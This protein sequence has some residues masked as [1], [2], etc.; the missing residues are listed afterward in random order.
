MP[1]T[2]SRAVTSRLPLWFGLLGGAAAW[3]VH[4]IGCW[5]TA[6]WG[7]FSGFDRWKFLG[8][9]LVAWIIVAL[10]IVAALVALG[11]TLVACRHYRRLSNPRGAGE[12]LAGK[13]ETNRFLALSGWI[14]SGL[15]LLIILVQSVP[16]L[17]FLRESS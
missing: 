11:A 6:E 2:A 1:E 5:A 13:G 4:F 9:T 14:L 7:G 15:F 10:S 17:Y 16:V 8:I 3:T 12:D